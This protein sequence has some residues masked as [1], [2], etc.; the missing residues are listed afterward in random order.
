MWKNLIKQ[1][2]TWDGAV[3]IGICIGF[4]LFNDIVNILAWAGIAYGA[5]T[6]WKDEDEVEGE[7]SGD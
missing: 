5:W 1:R 3:L 7:E 6:I 2:T 4:L